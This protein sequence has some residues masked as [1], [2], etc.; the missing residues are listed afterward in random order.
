MGSIPDTTDVV[1]GVFPGTSGTYTLIMKMEDGNNSQLT[2]ITFDFSIGFVA[3]D[4]LISALGLSHPRLLPRDTQPGLLRVKNASKKLM[5]LGLQFIPMEQIIRDSVLKLHEIVNSPTLDAACRK[6]DNLAEKNQ[7]DSTLM[8]MITKAWSFAKES[9]MVKDEAKDIMYY[10]YMNT[11]EHM[12]KNVSKEA[13]ILKYLL[14]VED[15]Y[16]L[17]YDLKDAFT[18]GGELVENPDFVYAYVIQNYFSLICC[19]ISR[20]S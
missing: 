16:K 9:H 17:L 12:Q 15:T 19:F 6:I 7:L 10:L 20:S 11:R 3:S 2:C 8:L 14:I 1:A 13:R 5:D 18:P 4:H